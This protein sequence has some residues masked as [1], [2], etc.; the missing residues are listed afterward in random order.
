MEKSLKEYLKKIQFQYT[1]HKHPAVFH[2]SE[3]KDLKKDIPGMHTKS[4]FLRDKEGNY[5][6]VCMR[7]E[8]RLDMKHL[9]SLLQVKK[10]TFASPEELK[11]EL[12]LTP[13][14]VSIFGIL[15][16][17]H[18]QLIIDKELWE[19]ERVNFHPNINTET[20]EFTHEHLETFYNS[21]RTKKEILDL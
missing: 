12:N 3:S 16:A 20:L 5:Y 2:V 13:G 10:L 1:L 8:K 11:S 14:S 15:H 4:L 21:L 7:G 9:E 6:L 17:H 19:A 18:T